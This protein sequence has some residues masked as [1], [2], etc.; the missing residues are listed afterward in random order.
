MISPWVVQIAATPSASTSLDLLQ[1]AQSKVAALRSAQPFTE[2]VS[3]GSETL[4]RARFAGFQS[5]DQ[6]WSACAAL[7]RANF[8]CY[9]VAN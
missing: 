9:A 2:P 8:S 5:K 4:H 7:K 1:K 6:A 3:S